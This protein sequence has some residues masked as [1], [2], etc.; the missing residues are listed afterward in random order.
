[1]ASAD[2]EL[3]GSSYGV[4]R[5]SK[6]KSNVCK[7][8]EVILCCLSLL[9]SSVFTGDMLVDTAAGWREMTGDDGVGTGCE[10]SS[11][12]DGGGDAV[13]A[14]ASSPHTSELKLV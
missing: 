9:L 7:V 8:Y 12:V 5:I 2:T 13:S 6:E 11:S 4:E 1:M 3:D 10:L 14:T